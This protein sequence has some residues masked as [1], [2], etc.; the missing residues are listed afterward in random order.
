MQSNKIIVKR[1][2]E[3]SGKIMG[4]F[5][6]KHLSHFLQIYI[7]ARI[8]NTLVPL[9]Y[10]I[11]VKHQ[12]G[13]H[14][15]METRVIVNRALDCLRHFTIKVPIEKRHLILFDLKGVISPLEHVKRC[16]GYICQQKQQ[17]ISEFN[18]TWHVY[19]KLDK[20]MPRAHKNGRLE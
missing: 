7:C 1:W 20:A 2:P 10:K 13:S 12:E 11:L 5:L 4:H 16:M 9:L 6:W 17:L 14:C 18:A 15:K 8:A 3:F 19:L